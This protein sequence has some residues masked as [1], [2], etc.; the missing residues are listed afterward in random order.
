MRCHGMVYVRLG[1]TGDALEAIMDFFKRTS[2]AA[3]AYAGLLVFD[4]GAYEDSCKGKYCKCIYV[5]GISGLV[6]RNN[7][8]N[9]CG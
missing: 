7:A 6:V 4:T 5:S 3:I 8:L 2:P 9:N 1:R